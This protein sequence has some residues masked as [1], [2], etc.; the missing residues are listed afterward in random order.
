MRKLG[1]EQLGSDESARTS[2]DCPA[3]I[4]MPLSATSRLTV[5]ASAAG[6]ARLTARRPGADMLPSGRDKGV[7]RW[8]C[9]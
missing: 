6:L 9:G 3:P 5:P 7:Q 1:D 4:R 8:I 2:Y